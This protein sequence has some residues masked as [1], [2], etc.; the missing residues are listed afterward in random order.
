MKKSTW[1]ITLL[2]A[3]VLAAVGQGINITRLDSF[4]NIL[5]SKRLA[6]GSLAISK[7]GVIQYQ[8]TIGYS[9]GTGEFKMADRD[10]KYRVGS[11]AKMFTA[12]MIF[13]LMEEGKLEQEE[14]LSTYFP[15]L[16]N[17]DKITIGH[18]LC[19]RSGLHD[20][21]SDTDFFTWMDKPKSQQELL[22]IITQKGSDF[23][24]GTRAGYSNSNYLLLGY[25][26]ERVCK[27]PYAAALK[28][29]INSK[30]KLRNTYF[31]KPIDKNTS[32]TASY[33]Y[34]DN[35]WTPQK[36]TDP[37]LHGGAGS[38]VSTPGDLVVFLDALFSNVLISKSSLDKMKTMVD[39]YGMG[40]FANKYG[41]K[42]SF[43]HNGRIEEFYTALWHFPGENL[44]VAYCTNGI[45]YPRT[46]IIEGVLKICFNQPYAIPFTNKDQPKSEELDKYLGSYSSGQIVVNCTK[47]GS[48]LLL[49]T[50]GKTFDVEK[51]N[52]HY[53]MNAAS[54]YFFEFIPGKGQLQ[55]KETDNVYYLDKT[56]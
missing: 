17:A 35:S 55:I 19:H 12:V 20:Y 42:P 26:I 31:G 32:E 52:E 11:A 41:N 50:R 34:S 56:D 24:P 44:S 5:A 2:A 8:R 45:N 54:G 29:R 27:M 30:L 21:S 6:M 36:E 16:P 48:N 22:E 47:D 14:K 37:V 39:D 23:Q 33:K 28:K 51:I 7:N 40:I 18:M 53:F 10:T 1:L 46:D 3:P 4:V 15:G 43:G 25:I 38:I 9:P 13:Q 49:E